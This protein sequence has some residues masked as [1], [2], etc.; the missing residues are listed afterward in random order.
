[1]YRYE[2]KL[3]NTQ[4][5]LILG[6]VWLVLAVVFVLWTKWYWGFAI[7]GVDRPYG[8]LLMR[9]LLGVFALISFGWIVPLSI[10]VLKLLRSVR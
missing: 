9:V 7:L 10:G 6:C 1:M 2:A 3:T 4:S 8:R 5:M